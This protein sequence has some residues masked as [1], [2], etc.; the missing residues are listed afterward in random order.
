[1][2]KYNLLYLIW[3]APGLARIYLKPNTKLSFQGI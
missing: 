1:M 3:V 2:V